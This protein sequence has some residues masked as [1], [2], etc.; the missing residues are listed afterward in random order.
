MMPD[1][2][3]IAN[4]AIMAEIDRR[5]AEQRAA[6]NRPPVEDCQ[7]CDEPIPPARRALRLQL[8]IDCARRRESVGRMFSKD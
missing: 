6:A 7:D 1:E 3:D 4:D 2:A 8:C 5:I